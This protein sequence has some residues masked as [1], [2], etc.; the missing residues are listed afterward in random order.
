MMALDKAVNA[1]IRILEDE[2]TPTMEKLSAARLIIE[3]SLKFREQQ[4]LL[5]R[6]EE[7]EKQM[8]GVYTL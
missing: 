8:K 4:T 7:L 1:I 2:R 3:N 6:V 5:Q